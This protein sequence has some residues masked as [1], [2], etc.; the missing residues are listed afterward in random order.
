MM[1]V[2]EIRIFTWRPKWKCVQGTKS[3][4][5]LNLLVLTQMLIVEKYNF[6]LQKSLPDKAYLLIA[7]LI[8]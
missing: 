7:E 6:S 4:A 2:E 3:F 5:K 1:N 8:L